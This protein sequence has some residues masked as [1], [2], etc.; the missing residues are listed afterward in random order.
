[1][2]FAKTFMYDAPFSE[3]MRKD[4]GL[5]ESTIG[6]YTS[7]V[8]KITNELLKMKPEYSSVDE[9]VRN[10]DLNQLKDHWLSVPE[11][12]ELDE[13]GNSMYSSGF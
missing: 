10:E 1:M 5:S 7:A 13:R 6:K 3:W 12:K 2:S 8:Y 4:T 9:L 11:N